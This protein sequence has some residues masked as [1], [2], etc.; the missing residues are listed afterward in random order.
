MEKTGD[1]LLECQPDRVYF[2][3]PWNKE[4]HR[5]LKLINENRYT[6]AFKIKCCVQGVVFIDPPAGLIPSGERFN[7]K[8]VACGSKEGWTLTLQ[9][10]AIQGSEHVMDARDAWA[11]HEGLVGIRQLHMTYL[12][13]S[14]AENWRALREYTLTVI[15]EVKKHGAIYDPEHEQYSNTEQNVKSRNLIWEEI[16]RAVGKPPGNPKGTAAGMNS[17][18]E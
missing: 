4:S 15:Y 2:S 13:V 8:L 12:P 18:V 17:F 16:G 5:V 11:K 9:I 1:L 14:A 6:V 3:G 10:K 7:V